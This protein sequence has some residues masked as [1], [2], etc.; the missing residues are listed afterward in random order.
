MFKRLLNHEEAAD[1]AAVEEMQRKCGDQEAAKLEA[2]LYKL[3][4]S[5]S[6]GLG[7]FPLLVAVPLGIWLVAV[8]T[9]ARLPDVLLSL[10]RYEA[11][12]A[13]YEAKM[14]QPGLVKAQLDIAQA[15]AE[16][17]KLQPLLAVAQLEK[18]QAEAKA[19]AFQ[20][21]LVAAQAL[22]AEADSS[23]KAIITGDLDSAR[24]LDFM[25]DILDPNH[26]GLVA[27]GIIDPMKDPKFLSILASLPAKK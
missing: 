19:A 6:R 11:T 24:R 14:L 2:D 12:R 16:A 8:E 13:E 1:R 20:P 15:E 21:A 4:R 7:S 25:F 9:A 18:A 3:R 27:R 23:A 5:Q 22:Q 10:P 17:K 26:P